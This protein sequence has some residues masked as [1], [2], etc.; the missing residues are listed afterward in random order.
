MPTRDD[1]AMLDVYA[2][3]L[4]ACGWVVLLVGLVLVV[5]ALG[6][7]SFV[8]S[9]GLLPVAAGGIA[10]LASAKLLRCVL[11]I[12]RDTRALLARMPSQGDADS[13]LP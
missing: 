2:L 3:V 12:H 7:G 10:L 1:F 4:A 13:A 5:V 11:A 9:A 8:A 6:E